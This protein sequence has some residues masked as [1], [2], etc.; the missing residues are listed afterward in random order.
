[1]ADQGEQPA[2]SHRRLKQGK[3]RMEAISDGVFAV[4]MTLLV[5]DLAIPLAAQKDLV[6]ALLHEWP[7][8][9]GF[10]VSFATIGTIWLGHNTMTEYLERVDPVLL[11]LNLLLLFFVCLLPFAT[12]LLGEFRD[13]EGA[14]RVASVTY[15]IMLLLCSVL[16][17]VLWRYA[18]RAKL[19]APDLADD[20]ISLLTTRLTPGLGGYVVLIVLGLFFP[21]ISVFGY[22]LVAVFLL[23]PLRPRMPRRGGRAHPSTHA[24]G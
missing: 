24:R 12:G 4:A 6:G 7:G 13:A 10:L 19:V 2:P 1:M 20:E 11:R 23:L 5:L 14:E 22:L 17:S 21:K 9:L 8:Y 3:G 18:V 16:L 15:G